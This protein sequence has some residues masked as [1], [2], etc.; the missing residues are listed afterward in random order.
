MFDLAKKVLPHTVTVRGRLYDIQTDYRYWLR[1]S[2]HIREKDART[3]DFDYMYITKKPED[4]QAG[5][6]ALIDFLQPK[7]ELPRR[8]GDERT[9]LDY[10]LDA[11][12]IYAAFYERY[13]IDLFEVKNLHW[14]KFL[15]LLRGIH[16]TELNQI[17]SARLYQ[18]TDKGGES[19]RA[20]MKQYE[21]WRLP[22]PE[23]NEPDEALEAFDRELRG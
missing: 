2:E 10:K 17:M 6:N 7:T 3:I 12:Y 4:R 22:E 11:P 19:E 14:H 23:D 1:F 18:P 16:D 21:A 5:I 8:T 9:V 20:R 15:A 13:S